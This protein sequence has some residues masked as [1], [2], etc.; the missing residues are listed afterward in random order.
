MITATVL[1]YEVISHFPDKLSL[2]S[3][4]WDGTVFGVIACGVA[5]AKAFG[6]NREQ[7]SQ[8]INLSVT[9]QQRPLPDPDRCGFPLEG[10]GHAKRCT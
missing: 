7:I 3:K 2:Q 4:G 1:A 10:S 9:P 8:A 6:L 5:A